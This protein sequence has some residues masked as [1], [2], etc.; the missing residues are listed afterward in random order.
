[1]DHPTDWVRY[2][3]MKADGQ[4]KGKIVPTGKSGPMIDVVYDISHKRMKTDAP[5]GQV[6]EGSVTVINHIVSASGETLPWGDCDL[7][8]GEEILRLRHCETG[9]EWL[10]LS[11]D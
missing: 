8:V 1:M 4:G 7:V 3:V 10:V 9:P 6:T 5:S 11:L 2:P